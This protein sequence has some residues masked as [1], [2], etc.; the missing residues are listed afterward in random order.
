MISMQVIWQQMQVPV[1]LAG[2]RSRWSFYNFS[3]TEQLSDKN[4]WLKATVKLPYYKNIRIIP[5]NYGGTWSWQSDT[6][7][8]DNTA[9]MKM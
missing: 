3:G 6:I 8:Y 9:K 7:S 2:W 1:D 5:T 4:T